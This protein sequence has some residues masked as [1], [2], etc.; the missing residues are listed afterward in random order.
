MGGEVRD[1]DLAQ[2]AEVVV[3]R[4]AEVAVLGRQ[5]AHSSG[6]GAVAHQVAQEP[7]GVGLFAGHVIEHRA[8]RRQVA[9]HV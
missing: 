6:L 8:E 1:V 7:H 4:Q 5:L 9:M 2:H 3:A